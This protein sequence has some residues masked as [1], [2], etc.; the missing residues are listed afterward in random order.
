MVNEVDNSRLRAE[1]DRQPRKIMRLISSSHGR[2]ILDRRK[3]GSETISLIHFSLSDIVE[4]I[5]GTGSAR[6]QSQLF[7]GVDEVIDE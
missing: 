3:P 7:E 2:L 6:V 1:H 4:D 5:Q